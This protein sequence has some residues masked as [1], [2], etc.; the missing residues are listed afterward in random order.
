M[1]ASYQGRMPSLE[2]QALRENK[3]LV[4]N[5]LNA[6]VVLYE[7]SDQVNWIILCSLRIH[8]WECV[9]FCSLQM[10]TTTA[11]SLLGWEFI[12]FQLRSVSVLLSLQSLQ[13]VHVIG[14]WLMCLYSFNLLLVITITLVGLKAKP[15]IKEFAKLFYERAV[16]LTESLTQCH[17]QASL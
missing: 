2:G 14:T 5:W 15:V 17:R 9:V 4:P 10:C 3:L 6:M 8:E 16:H 1:K 12:Q 13:I 11:G 7:M